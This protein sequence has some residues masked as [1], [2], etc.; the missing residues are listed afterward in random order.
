MHVG[1][2]QVTILVFDNYQSGPVPLKI[3][4]KKRNKTTAI[5]TFQ[6]MDEGQGRVIL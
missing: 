2:H 5:F 1:K 4:G 6:E 3:V